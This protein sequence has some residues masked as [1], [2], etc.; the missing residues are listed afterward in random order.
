MQKNGHKNG[1]LN[2]SCNVH[3]FLEKKF[4]FCFYLQYKLLTVTSCMFNNLFLNMY[5]QQ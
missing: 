1:F 3:Y 4:K 5:A 2:Q